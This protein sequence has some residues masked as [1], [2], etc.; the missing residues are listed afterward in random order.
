MSEAEE[1]IDSPSPIGLPTDIAA[2]QRREKNQGPSAPTK[3]HS[4]ARWNQAIHNAAKTGDPSKAE[5]LL[6]EIEWSG[7]KPDTI[8]YNSVIHAFAKNGDIEQARVQLE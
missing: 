3:G 8:S 2:A 6:T 4:V 7:L 1:A 5:R